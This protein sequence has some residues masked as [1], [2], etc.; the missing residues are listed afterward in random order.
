MDYEVD[1]LPVGDSNGDAICLRYGTPA[2]FGVHVIDGG[3]TDTADT[4]LS[5][6]DD[7]Y[8]GRRV[9][10]MVLS[11]AD[12]DHACGLVGVVKS[13]DVGNLWMNR[14]WL[15]APQIIDSF[16]G[17][18]TLAGLIQEIKDKHPYLVE[19]E[20]IANS[21]G[22]PIHPVFA[23]RRIG[24][25]F[26]VLAPSEQRYI[27]L[28]PDL[29]KTPQSYE[30]KKGILGAV[31][32]GARNVLDM[33]R[34]AWDI[35]TL[36]DNPP[37]TSASNE[38][39]VVQMG[40]FGTRRVLLTA[41][42]GPDGLREA[43]RYARALGLYGAPDFVQVP[44]HGSRRNVTPSVLN[45][46]LG[47]PLEDRN[48]RRGVAFCSVGKDADIYPRK[49]VKN[50]FMRRGYPVHATRG[51]TKRHHIGWGERS[52]WKVSEPEAFDPNVG[53]ED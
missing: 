48:S 17:N 19:L 5:H 43:T 4:V 7:H 20:A 8:G 47:A 33:V 30:D 21:R 44:H 2:A 16:H 27:S 35:E 24:P 25:C 12:N 41:D 14:P 32:G 53:E 50:A 28:L 42:V 6:L 10:H 15:Y 13:A 29:G 9:D 37:A 3:F 22:I 39:S 38:T 51:W 18:W 45:E 26:T 11:H 36:D 40:V 23:G 49:K 46:W 1:M 34:E 52:G 31:F